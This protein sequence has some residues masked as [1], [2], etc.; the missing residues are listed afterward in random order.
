MNRTVV[1]FALP[2]TAL[3]VWIA[4]TP[5]NTLAAWLTHPVV[6]ERQGVDVRAVT[7][8]GALWWRI[9][10]AACAA[11]WWIVGLLI[12]RWIARGAIQPEV[13]QRAAPLHARLL[14][15]AG[16]VIVVGITERI[17][18]I[19]E[20]FW[21][22]EI[23]ALI[24]YA[25]HGPGPI[26]GTYFVPSNHVMHT[27]LSW[28]AITLLG[29]I[30]EVILRVPALVAGLLAIPAVAWLMHEACCS[31]GRS[32]QPRSRVLA[33]AA[34][35]AT[36]IAPIVVLESCEARGY[37]LMIL[38]AALSSALLLRGMRTASLACL[39]AFA[40]S[41]ALGIWSHLVFAGLSIGQ[42]ITL[43]VWMLIVRRDSAALRVSGAALAA[44]CLGAI[45]ACTLLTPLLPDML[46]IRREFAAL[47]GNEP[48]LLSSEGLH[49]L[50][51][52]G[53][54][55]SW[56]AVP[57]LILVC[58]GIVGALGDKPR[59]L[60]LAL[61]LLGLPV[62]ALGT[63]LGGSWMYARFGLFALPGCI[64]AL[65]LGGADIVAWIIRRT[66]VPKQAAR[67]SLIATIL[68]LVV[69][70]PWTIHLTQLPPKQ[71]LRDA[72][73]WVLAKDPITARIG[74]VGLAD[75]V[76][77]YYAVLRGIDIVPT[78]AGGNRLDALDRDIHWLIVLY[79]RSIDAKASAALQNSW[80]EHRRL[81]GWVDWT[82]GDVII[83]R[84]K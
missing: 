63:A 41:T 2:V 38:C 71:P 52:L 67:R 73:E 78:G 15:L 26:I 13:P 30:N 59:R 21:Y 46:R 80:S 54:A 10:A 36:A 42:G 48:S 19:T 33:V 4:G 12:A 47:D 43:L 27:L 23:S 31:V 49:L 69:A 35:A 75:N 65:V 37:S 76:L 61:M 32:V 79:P 64:A 16:F 62:V 25:Q 84:R 68:V 11:S 5:T 77:A 57:A 72:V 74:T 29:G 28:C 6:A 8:D 51:G 53:G 55:W 1:A 45:T 50:L 39:L 58:I 18:R 14:L 3:G 40:L 56:A 7:L 44:L 70:T 24:D 20:S 9:A 81:Q 17:W 83:Y 60:P 34:A 22:D 82:N 66:P